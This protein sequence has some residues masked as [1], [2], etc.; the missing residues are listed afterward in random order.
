MHLRRLAVMVAAALPFCGAALA[1][2]VELIANTLASAKP[3]PI[4]VSD[5]KD[6]LTHNP[7]AI[8]PAS[9]ADAYGSS[10]AHASAIASF[11]GLHAY[12]DAYLADPALGETQATA[13]ASYADYFAPGV[14]TPGV[15]NLLHIDITGSTS[16]QPRFGPGPSAQ[17]TWRIDDLTSRDTL[18]LGSWNQSKAATDFY[19][20]YIVPGLDEIR[21]YVDLSLFVYDGAQSV[22]G[23][24]Y[25]DYKDTVLSTVITP[26]GA[27][28]I[29]E[30]GHDY[31]P[32]PIAAPEPG[33][34]ALI[35][36][37][38]GALG[39]IARGRRERSLA[40]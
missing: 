3:S 11:N 37:G 23:V 33:A 13:E 8:V 7:A 4:S 22:P 9:A 39:A 40:A 36:V 1:N 25:A 2:P 31:A 26:S 34:W 20:P 18:A 38:F 15:T 16:P 6:V 32:P 12:A 5:D 17:V 14:Y 21:L 10:Y 27:S 24:V 30:S 29:G 19:V 28:V 35:L